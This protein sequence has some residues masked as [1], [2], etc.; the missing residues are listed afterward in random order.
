[1]LVYDQG[2]TSVTKL[3]NLVLFVFIQKTAVCDSLF[4]PIIFG[5]VLGFHHNLSWTEVFH[6]EKSLGIS[7][8]I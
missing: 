1:M 5:C 8:H 4:I 3:Y 2:Y 7:D 6:I